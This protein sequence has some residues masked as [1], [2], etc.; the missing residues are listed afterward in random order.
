MIPS[1]VDSDP[2]A[3]HIGTLN[4]GSLHAALKDHYAQPGDEFEVRLDQFVIDIMR[5]QGKADELLIEV[6]TGS[7]AAMGNKFDHL[8]PDHR[9]LMVH[10]IAVETRLDKPGAKPRKSPRRGSVY[11]VLDELVSI[12]T[13]LDHPN[14]ALDVVLVSVTKVQ[15]VDPKARRGRGGFR[16]VDRKLDGIHEVHHFGGVEDL[17]QLLPDE[18]PATFTTADIAQLAGISRDTAQR[19]AYCFKA[20]CLF[21]QVDRT[22]AG[23]IYRRSY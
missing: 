6:Q 9:M 19:L 17:N 1:S 12:P 8:L 14:L 16:T 11:G 7:F 23:I 5:N 2:A 22:K 3:P 21:D 15:V 13:L 20:A 10:P 18:L 4:E